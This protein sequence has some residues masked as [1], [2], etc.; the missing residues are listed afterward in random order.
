MI[1]KKK[2]FVRPKKLYEKS[3]IEEENKLVDKY[4][5]KNKREIWKTIAKIRYF[6]HRAKDLAKA[7]LEE[8]QVLFKKLNSLGLKIGNIADVLALD[9]ESLLKR[10]LPSIIAQ[11]NLA[12]TVKQARQ[13]VVHKKVRIDGKVVNIPSYI[14][15]IAE[16]SKIVVEALPVQKA[17][18]SQAVEAEA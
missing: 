16:E 7:S 13:L 5:L 4:G 14:V 3:R 1:R 10:R 9:L 6:R 18:S 11:K 12:N 8:Q 17:E 2:G 15:S